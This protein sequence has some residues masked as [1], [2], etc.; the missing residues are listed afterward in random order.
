MTDAIGVAP[1]NSL[2]EDVAARVE[3]R[4]T[5]AGRG[6]L[7]VEGVVALKRTLVIATNMRRHA[8]VIAGLQ[9]AGIPA[10]LIDGTQL[11]PRSTR[12]TRRTAR[13]VASSK[14]QFAE[15]THGV[16]LPPGAT[17]SSGPRDL[18]V[19]VRRAPG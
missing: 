11:A 13:G 12:Q 19:V 16:E 14:S 10:T 4:I 8:D 5:T 2:I 1:E 7:T 17:V 15:L 9:D 3:K 18:R 6:S